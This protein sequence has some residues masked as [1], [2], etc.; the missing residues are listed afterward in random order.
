MGC[1][2]IPILDALRHPQQILRRLCLV[3]S[4]AT[5]G[6][7]IAGCGATT[8]VKFDGNKAFSYLKAQCD[9]GPR[10]PN[11]ETHRKCGDYLVNSLKPLADAVSEQNFECQVDQRTL[12]LRN[13]I[14]HFHPEMKEYILLCAH[15][16]TRPVADEEVDKTKAAKPILGAND[17]ASGVAVLLELAR[18][19]HETPPKIGVM[20]VFFD[21]EDYGATPNLMFMGSKHFAK[22]LGDL[23]RAYGKPIKPRYGIL[24]DMVGDRN[25][26]IY[27]ER[28]SDGKAPEIVDKVWKAAADLGYGDVF[29]NTNK[30]YVS[31]DHTPLLA[32]GIKCIDVIDFDYP[33]WHTLDDTVDKCSPQSLQIVG[34]VIAKVIYSEPAL[35][36]GKSQS[37]K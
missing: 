25:L 22:K 7:A 29:K 17:G 1:R 37:S 30:Y 15:W 13:I 28:F 2:R 11:T 12:N 34:D 33:Y 9:F 3:T 36:T 24:L 16:D 23:K 8:H 27:R 6:L 31:D 18:I 32:A 5:V 35:F 20:M 21:G 14:A 19:L 10:P 26:Q 4:I